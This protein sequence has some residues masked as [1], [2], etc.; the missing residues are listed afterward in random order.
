ML[1][2]LRKM[3][4]QGTLPSNS[5]LPRPNPRKRIS[6]SH[7]CLLARTPTPSYRCLLPLR[8]QTVS[9]TGP[10]RKSC[11]FTLVWKIPVEVSQKKSASFCSKDLLKVS[12]LA[13]IPTREHLLNSRQYSFSQNTQ[14]LWRKWFRSVHLKRVE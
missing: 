3:K 8:Y 9:W 2:S 14:N 1:S 12:D 7:S 4:R 6:G 10:Q 13:H 11:T 5:P